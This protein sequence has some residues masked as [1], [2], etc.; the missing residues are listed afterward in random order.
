VLLHAYFDFCTHSPA[1]STSLPP[2]LFLS[3]VD[4]VWHSSVKH[5]QLLLLTGRFNCDNMRLVACHNWPVHFLSTGRLSCSGHQCLADG[6]CIQRSS[7]TSSSLAAFNLQV[8][9]AD[10]D[11]R[12]Y[13]DLTTSLRL[14]FGC[15]NVKLRESRVRTKYGPIFISP[16]DILLL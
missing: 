6:R 15:S 12:T 13:D 4:H 9:A 16:S 7:S 8:W 3:L 10:Q 11:N 1:L 5:V 14:F 2:S